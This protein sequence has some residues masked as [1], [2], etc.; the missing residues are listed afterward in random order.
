MLEFHILEAFF[1]FYKLICV[2]KS[3]HVKVIFSLLGS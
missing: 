1:N 3:I 2:N